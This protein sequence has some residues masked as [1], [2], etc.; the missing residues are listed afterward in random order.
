[1]VEGNSLCPFND[2]P[3][4]LWYE[5]VIDSTIGKGSRVG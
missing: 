5:V 2:T 1:M 4:L 3:K